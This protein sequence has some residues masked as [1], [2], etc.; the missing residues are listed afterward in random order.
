MNNTNDKQNEEKICKTPETMSISEKVHK[1][2]NDKNDHIT[3]EDIRNADIDLDANELKDI[4]ANT[5]TTEPDTTN[6]NDIHAEKDIITLWDTVD[7]N[8]TE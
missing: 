4:H 7:K 3:D 5:N 8:A 1:H 2:L 6:T